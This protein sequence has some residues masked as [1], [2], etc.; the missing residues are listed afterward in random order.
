MFCHRCRLCISLLR[1]KGNVSLFVGL[2]FPFVGMQRSDLFA[3]IFVMYYWIPLLFLISW[4]HSD[5]F[6]GVEVLLQGKGAF[7]LSV[8]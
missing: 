6:P 5:E 1:K 2:S 4:G 7:V 8:C 3:R